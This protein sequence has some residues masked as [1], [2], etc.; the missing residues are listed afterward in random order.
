MRRNCVFLLEERRSQ[1]DETAEGPNDAQ[2]SEAC[3]DLTGSDGGEIDCESE[4]KD[5]E[6]EEEE[7]GDR[8]QYVY[9]LGGHAGGSG[10]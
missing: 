7:P 3:E 5:S 10:A 2:L 4:E 9:D 8:F 1:F 6:E